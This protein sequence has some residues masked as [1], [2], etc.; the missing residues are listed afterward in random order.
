MQDRNQP[1]SQHRIQIFCGATYDV[2]VVVPFG[3]THLSGARIRSTLEGCGFKMTYSD[4]ATGRFLLA[5]NDA[6]CT[7]LVTVHVPEPGH[8]REY[9]ITDITTLITPA[10]TYPCAVLAWGT[11]FFLRSN[12]GETPDQAGPEFPAAIDVAVKALRAAS[13]PH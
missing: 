7:M 9:R 1:L 5:L 12:Y 10:E 3:R 2:H 13:V 11:K 8:P 4:P 6:D